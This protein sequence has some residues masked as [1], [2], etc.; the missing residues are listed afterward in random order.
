MTAHE[1]SLLSLLF[2]TLTLRDYFPIPWIW[3][4]LVTGLTVEYIAKVTIWDDGMQA[5]KGLAAST[6]F[7]LETRCHPSRVQANGN[8]TWRWTKGHLSESLDWAHS[9]QHQLPA[10][11]I[12]RIG[13]CSSVEHPNSVKHPDDIAWKR[14]QSIHRTLRK[15]NVII[16]SS[17]YVSW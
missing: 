9:W 8:A 11:W 12:P 13:D 7:L 16:I 15:K 5:L 1:P 14:D 2:L 17:H 10:M 4:G 6:S 3:A